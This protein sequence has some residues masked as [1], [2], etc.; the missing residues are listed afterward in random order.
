MMQHDYRAYIIP[1]IG[2]KHEQ[3]SNPAVMN[4]WHYA[5]RVLKGVKNLHVLGYSLP[6]GDFAIDTLLREGMHSLVASHS[7]KKILFVNRDQNLRQRAQ[8]YAFGHVTIEFPETDI[9]TY[10]RRFVEEAEKPL[11]LNVS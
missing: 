4:V 7:P 10:L 1:P 8:R 5:R 2:V 11:G 9:L 3:Y 6:P